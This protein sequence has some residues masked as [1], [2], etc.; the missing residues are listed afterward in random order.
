[1]GDDVIEIAL[2]HDFDEI[3]FDVNERVD[4]LNIYIFYMI[5]YKI[6]VLSNFKKFVVGE[7]YILKI[8]RMEDDVIEIVLEH[9]F[10][11]ITFDDNE[12]VDDF[13]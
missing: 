5:I 6:C 9:D 10:D 12:R 8:S 1:M 4:D 7:G 2:E 3:T 11:E 13:I